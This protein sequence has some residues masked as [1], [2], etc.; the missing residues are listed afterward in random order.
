[1]RT[2]CNDQYYIIKEAWQHDAQISQLRERER[3][4]EREKE[5]ERTGSHDK[6]LVVQSKKF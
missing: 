6:H 3:E 5:R 4:R 2:C 1:M